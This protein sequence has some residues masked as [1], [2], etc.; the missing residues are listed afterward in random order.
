MSKIYKKEKFQSKSLEISIKSLNWINNFWRHKE[1]GFIEDPKNSIICR[2]NPHMHLLEASLSWEENDLQINKKVWEKLSDEI[3]DLSITK[4]IDP[5][6][7]ILHELF[8]PNWNL[9]LKPDEQYIEPGHQYEWAWLII[10]WCNLRKNYKYIE[11][12]NELINNAEKYGYDKKRKVCINS[13]DCNLKY[14]DRKAKL[15]P[16]TERLKALLY[17]ESFSSNKTL[18]RNNINDAIQSIK[19]Y[20]QN[21]DQKIWHECI[22]EKGNFTLE[23]TKASSFYHVVTALCCLEDYFN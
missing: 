23:P 2:A 15:W 5:K 8:D 22:D 6:R 13:L 10:K 12:A 18:I 7:K 4:L 9:S 17:I 1:I 11:I 14:L 19:N 20:L 21:T 16:Q 3:I